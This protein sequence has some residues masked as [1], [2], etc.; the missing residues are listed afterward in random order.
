VASKDKPFPEGF[1]TITPYL[2]IKGAA[3][4]ID[5]YKAAFGATELFRMP[6]PDGRVGHAELRIGDSVFMLADEFPEMNIV[7]PKTLGGSAVGLLLHVPDADALFAKAV[8]LGA[9]VTKPMA[10]QF[11]GD[12]SGTVEDPFGHRWTISTHIEDVSLE[13][14]KRRAAA[15]RNR[16]DKERNHEQGQLQTRRFSQRHALPHCQRRGQTS[17]LHEAGIRRRGN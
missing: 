15:S 9:Q 13:E 6:Q 4:A 1:H 2:V 10:D 17:R 5:F 3:V 11:Y 14:V 7:G 8:S 16:S 12:R